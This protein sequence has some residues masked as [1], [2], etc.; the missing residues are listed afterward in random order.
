MRLVRND[1]RLYF[2]PLKSAKPGAPRGMILLVSPKMLALPPR[3]SCVA[4]EQLARRSSPRQRKR[5]GDAGAVQRLLS[6]FT[7]VVHLPVETNALADE[8][9][10]E[11]ANDPKHHRQ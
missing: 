11:S 3:Q 5:E 7:R 9:A 10:D 4:S 2:D 6:K 8:H 1:P